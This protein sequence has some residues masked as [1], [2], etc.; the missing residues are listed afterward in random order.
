MKHAL[1]SAFLRRIRFI[2]QFPF[3]GA[4]ER[5]K[6]WQRVFPER[7]PLGNL[8]FARIS[9][10]N[11]AGGL[12]RN[13]AL[14]AAFRAADKGSVVGMEEILHAAK[15]EYAKLDRPLTPAEIGGWT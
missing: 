2:L 1:D 3:P 8:D 5:S 12:I 11:I 14:H 15:V 10:L 6:I 7:T 4:A 13:I 9:Q